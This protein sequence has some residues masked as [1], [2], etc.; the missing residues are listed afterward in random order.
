[1]SCE[2][3]NFWHRPEGATCLKCLRNGMSF[4]LMEEC[5]A[6]ESIALYRT[7]ERK[8]ERHKISDQ[9][10][11][12]AGRL[13]EDYV[14]RQIEGQTVCLYVDGTTSRRFRAEERH[15]T[16]VLASCVNFPR[17]TVVCVH[18]ATGPGGAA[19]ERWLLA[20]VLWKLRIPMSKVAGIVSDN[21]A[22]VRSAITWL[23]GAVYGCQAS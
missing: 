7:M 22:N 17:P 4:R 20:N 16:V 18:L 6:D 14:S 19:E 23:S 15:V 13:F 11:P 21:A 5:F 10:L 9:Y 1:M 8:P 12:L 2:L 3:Q